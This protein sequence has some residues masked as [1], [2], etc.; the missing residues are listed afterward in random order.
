LGK[1]TLKAKTLKHFS[2]DLQF[3]ILMQIVTDA[4]VL[5][6]IAIARQIISFIYLT[7]VPGFVLLKTIRLKTEK[8]IDTLLYSVGLDIAALMFIGLILNTLLPIAGSTSSLSTMPLLMALN[9][10]VLFCCVLVYLRDGSNVVRKL[11]LPKRY[12]PLA[13]MP[14]LAVVGAFAMT[15]WGRNLVLLIMLAL[16]PVLVTFLTLWQR[17]FSPQ[18]LGLALF[19]IALAL[20]LHTSMVTNYLVG[21]DINSEFQAFQLTDNSSHWISGFG[22]PDTRIS[23]GYSML[24]VT[25]FPT[26]YSKIGAIDGTLL[27]KVLFPLILS[28][29][30]LAL[31]SFYSSKI[32]KIEAFLAVFLILS[33]LT[34]FNT[35]GFPAKQMIAEFFFV[36]LFLVVLKNDMSPFHRIFLFLIFG[37]GMAL[38]H[39]AMSY[40]FLFFLLVPWVIYKASHYTS[41]G[42]GRNTRI[43][44]SFIVLLFVMTFGWYV[45]TSS[46]APFEALVNFGGQVSRNLFSDFFNPSSRT[47]TVLRGIGVT[48]ATSF[49]HL[50]GRLFFYL[51]EFLIILGVLR[52]LLKKDFARFGSDYTMFSILSLAILIF[53]IIVPNFARFF[54]VERFY[55]I[56][57]LF[58]APFFIIGIQTISGFLTTHAL[59][60]H[61]EALALGLILIAVVPLFFFETGFIYETTKDFSYSVPL[62]MY[63]IDKIS[64]YDRTTDAREVAAALWLSSQQD[65][66]NNLVYCD[67][68]SLSNVLTSYGMMSGENLRELPNNTRFIDDADYVYLRGI[69]TNLG[70]I[71]GQDKSFNLSNIQWVLE[72]QC[73]V[74]SNKDATVFWVNSNH[75]IPTSP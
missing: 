47:T 43:G 30:P 20:L 24:S 71:I 37:A 61:K 25:I 4:V 31:Y 72:N 50:I 3:I 16:M 52:T 58:L 46:S 42:L 53:C 9:I 59:K 69:N 10:V 17:K 8:S 73:L 63:R 62:S 65:P 5:L 51:S 54:R 32:S 19:A 13:I 1:L 68:V 39:Y 49:A 66:A 55:Q 28:L 11:E 48:E 64:L 26:V 70:I 45:Y 27:F 44:L 7:V 23:K 18:L 40:L 67:F 75:T 21:Y 35:E 22:S 36:L 56:S 15:V 74:Y 6:D 2:A 29:V 57:L 12:L 34:F 38:S 14:C 33:N 41:F 60:T